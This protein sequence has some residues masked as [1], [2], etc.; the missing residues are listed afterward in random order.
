M[1]ISKVQA[2]IFLLIEVHKKLYNI[3]KMYC[4]IIHLN[5]DNFI[6]QCFSSQREKSYHVFEN[7]TK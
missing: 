2:Q 4:R 3:Q 5:L 6:N 7:F 1:N